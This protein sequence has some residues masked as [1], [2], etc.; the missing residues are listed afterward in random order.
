MTEQQEIIDEQGIEF[1]ELLQ[2]LW[3]RRIFISLVALTV[4]VIGTVV[5]FAWP[6][7]YQ[8]SATILLEEPEVPE[9]LV[10]TTVTTFA[11]EQIQYVSEPC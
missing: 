2:E 11:V 6:T 1:S 7:S 10:Q 9:Q 4:F 3:R 5:V 8:S